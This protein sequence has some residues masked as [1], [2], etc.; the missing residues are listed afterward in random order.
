MQI[1]CVSDR[2]LLL[3]ARLR[4]WPALVLAVLLTG[5]VCRA[6]ALPAAEYLDTIITVDIAPQSLNK[7]LLQFGEQSH[8]QIMLASDAVVGYKTAGVKGTFS[9]RVALTKLLEGSGLSYQANGDTVTVVPAGADQAKTQADGGPA[10]EAEA[11]PR[12]AFPDRF[13]QAQANQSVSAETASAG[14]SSLEKSA[15]AVVKLEEVVVTAQKKSERIQ[16]VPVPITVLDTQLLA[17]NDQNRIQDYFATVPGLN[18]HTSPGTPG[19]G[20]Q[21]LSI[22]GLSTTAYSTPTVAVLIDDVPFGSST[23]TGSGSLLYPDI[24]P[25]DLARIEVL[26]GPQG[27][28]YGADS[29][30]GLIKFVTQDPS[31]TRFGANVQM[32]G[33]GVVAGGFGYGLRSAINL[34]ISDTLAFRVSG[35]SRQDPGYIENVTT[36]EKNI[37]FVN[38]YGGRIGALWHPS[39]A[40]S[41]KV[42]TLFQN[43]DANGN[44]SINANASFQPALGDLQQTGLG[45]T[46]TSNTRVRLYTATLDVKTSDVDI[47][48]VSG[49]GVNRVS[50]YQDYSAVPFFNSA[51]LSYANTLGATYPNQTQ[52][53]KFS[54]ELRASSEVGHW[55][56]WLGG[57]FYTHET[58]NSIARFDANTIPSGAYIS[59]I[60]TEIYPQTFSEYALF[61]DLTFHPTDRLDVQLGARQS[62]NRQVYDN[63]DYGPATPYYY[64]TTTSVYVQP[65]NRST[66]N[67]FTYLFTPDFK[68]SPHTMVYARIASGYQVGGPNTGVL[69]PGVPTSFKSDTT[70]NYEVGIKSDGFDHRLTLDASIYYV[71][72]HNLQLDVYEFPVS[73]YENAGRAKSEGVEW[74]LQAKPARGTDI[75]ISGAVNVAE[76]TE[77]LPPLS[78]VYGVAGNRLPFSSRFSGSVSVEQ[79]LLRVGDA[80]GFIGA[81]ASYVGLR[82]GEFQYSAAVPR[83]TYPA[84]TLVN[85]HAGVRCQSWMVNLFVNNI[86]N[87]RGILG[88]DL[89]GTLDNTG[90]FAQ[91]VQP[92]TVGV[93]IATHF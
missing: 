64:Q 82:Y 68:L 65:V 77:D 76:L 4:F 1:V 58:T 67:A 70:Q 59:T 2:R 87:K 19:G 12:G 93:S 90:Y 34:P 84:Y 23:Q 53:E 11:Q 32:L 73:Y 40:V 83:F 33:D 85:A 10:N 45:G 54:Q 20:R 25:S 3:Y 5:V 78:A 6:N 56:S 79:D 15:D 41:L 14:S 37:N 69:P 29:L 43:S 62:W 42:S 74:S 71:D 60:M 38:A 8:L 28:L 89:A 55:L 47:T 86:G 31:T 30:G 50:G 16:D 17:E 61:G 72:W 66:G 35:F 63:I 46:G 49:Y 36:G 26:K 13:H 9:A 75:A 80:T 7:A 22:R 81:S 52:T 92:R 24:D 48:S 51:T 44:P 88:G 57:L 21:F 27:T 18:L 39:Q 91:I